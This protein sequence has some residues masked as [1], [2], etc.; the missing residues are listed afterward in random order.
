MITALTNTGILGGMSTFS[1]FVYGTAEAMKTPGELAMAL[2]YV[3]A[4][5]LVGFCLLQAGGW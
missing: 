5:L 2:G 1:S 3:A 4:S